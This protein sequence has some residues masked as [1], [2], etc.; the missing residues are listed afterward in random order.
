MTACN[1]F[2]FFLCDE[3]NTKGKASIIGDLKV[4]SNFDGYQWSSCNTNEP[5]WEFYIKHGHMG[6]RTL[7]LCLPSLL[8]LPSDRNLR[9]VLIQVPDT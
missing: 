9:P 6:L 7:P 5:S 2:F 8:K 3:T 4:M 1:W